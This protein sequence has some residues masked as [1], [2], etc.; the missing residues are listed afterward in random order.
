MIHGLCSWFS[1]INAAMLELEAVD[2]NI[3]HFNKFNK[4]EVNF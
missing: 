1:K 2:P 4:G 3:E